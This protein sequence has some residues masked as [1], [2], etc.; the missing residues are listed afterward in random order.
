M[1]FG[2]VKSEFQPG[3]GKRINKVMTHSSGL[4]VYVVVVRSAYSSVLMAR[5]AQVKI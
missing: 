3:A 5:W 2:L 4:V 1:K